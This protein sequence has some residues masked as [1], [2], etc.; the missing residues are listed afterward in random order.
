MV[1]AARMEGL[2][3]AT[4]AVKLRPSR[5]ARGDTWGYELVPPAEQAAES[6]TFMVPWRSTAVLGRPWKIGRAARGASA[7]SRPH[8]GPHEKK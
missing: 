4:P 1:A 5:F 7:T 2:D 3:T 6:A 8:A